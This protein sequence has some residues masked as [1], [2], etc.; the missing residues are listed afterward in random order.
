MSGILKK[1]LRQAFSSVTA[2]IFLAAFSLAAGFVF[3]TGNLLVRN[4][5]LKVFFSSMFT[6]LLFL[7]PLLTMRLFSEEKRNRTEELL[8]TAPVRITEIILGKYIATLLLFL[9]G[10]APAF[11][12]PLVISLTGR[13]ALPEVLSN[14][15]GFF[16]LGAAFLAVGLFVSVLTA[17]Q[18]VAAVSTYALLLLLYFVDS[19]EVL[20]RH[21]IT[22][23]AVSLVS[24]RRHYLPLSYGIL[25]IADMLWF[26]SV[27]ALFLFLSVYA[28][29]R[30]RL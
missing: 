6:P 28:L 2:W 19:L 3:V 10:M 16:L 12:F 24:L 11:L 5:D 9:L 23:T 29:E 21:R 30:R 22:Q 8:L 17:H 4:G 14:V 20:H 18:L 27:T 13:L 1:E 26:A 15:L 7:L 25:D